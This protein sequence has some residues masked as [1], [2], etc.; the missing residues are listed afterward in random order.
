MSLSLANY[1]GRRVLVTGHTGFKGSWL[2]RW[3]ERLGATVAGYSLAPASSP[4]HHQLLSPTFRQWLADVRDLAALT[5]ACAEF[6]PEIVFHL[7][8]QPL[9]RQS[10]REPVETFATNV[11]G[12]A[13]VLE[14]CRQTDSVRAAVIVTTDKCY[15]NHEWAW[16]YRENDELGGHD[17]YS[18]SKACAELVSSSYRDSFL[19]ERGVLVATARAGN[20]I[21]GGDWADDRLIPDLVR[22]AVADE[23]LIVRNPQATRPWQH[24]LEPLA[25]YLLLGGGLL[26]GRSDLAEAW[27][28]GPDT[29]AN[30]SVGEMVARMVPHWPAVRCESPTMTGQPHE[31]SLLMLDSTK[32]RQLL[33]WQSRWDVDA[34]LARTA[35]WYR[36]YY[37]RG[38][39]LTDEQIDVYGACLSG[40][41]DA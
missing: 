6:Q 13:N 15:R 11:M 36:T 16:P 4:N 3:L 34:T 20:V 35:D 7:A 2:C 1:A 14:A 9:V 31:A 37:E 40:E 24:V 21:G 12:T 22:A 26:E 8:A 18:A 28:F 5:A 17:P 32:A 33:G 41:D 38:R 39:L 19:R 30:L 27:N 23:P 25:G 29:A 10:Y